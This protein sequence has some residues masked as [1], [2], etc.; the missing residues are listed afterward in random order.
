MRVKA[1]LRVIGPTDGLVLESEAR[2]ISNGQFYAVI[3]GL[4]RP[5]RE[6]GLD[7]LGGGAGGPAVL[8]AALRR[9]SGASARRQR[10]ANWCGASRRRRRSACPRGSRRAGLRVRH[11]Q[12]PA[13]PGLG[14]S[15]R[16]A[17]GDT[18][19][20]TR[21]RRVHHRVSQPRAVLRRT[22]RPR[23]RRCGADTGG[24]EHPA[25]EGVADR[26]RRAAPARHPRGGRGREPVDSREAGG[27]DQPGRTGRN[28]QRSDV[29]C[30]PRGGQRH[31]RHRFRI[32]GQVLAR[33]GGQRRAGR[34]GHDLR[35][36]GSG[37]ER[38]RCRS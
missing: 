33:R 24:G 11:L 26:A 17:A 30:L 36:A 27:A 28:G 4:P 23:S 29:R 2:A 10:G 20:G 1:D 12:P 9:Q 38:H 35:A 5:V 14:D 18:G 34:Q 37:S 32:P 22:G 3:D 7:P 13:G 31:R 15:G 21:P 19:T 8:R 25:D 16:T 6:P